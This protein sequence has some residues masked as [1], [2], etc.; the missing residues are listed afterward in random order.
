MIKTEKQ[1]EKFINNLHNQNFYDAHEDLEVIWFERRFE[2]NDEVNL[3]KGFINASVSFE[4][5]KRGKEEASDKVWKNYLKYRDL[6][7]FINSS[8]VEKYSAIIKKIDEVKNSF[9]D[10]KVELHA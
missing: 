7:H 3:L 6:I 9:K 8:H 5:H 4:L 1:F 2:Q 10:M